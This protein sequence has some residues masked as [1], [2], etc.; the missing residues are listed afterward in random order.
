MKRNGNT[1]APGKGV[2]L[3]YRRCI[4]DMSH[5]R[6]ENMIRRALLEG[7]IL[8]P[9]GQLLAN[10]CCILFHPGTQFMSRYGEDK[11]PLPSTVL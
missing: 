7:C 5:L 4:K 3:Q 8:G 10:S 11:K 1:R 6:I 2:Q 9:E